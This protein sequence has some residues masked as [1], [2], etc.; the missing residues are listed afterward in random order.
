MGLYFCTMPGKIFGL[1]KNEKLKSRKA[2]EELFARG[3]SQNIF[4][5]RVSY[6]FLPAEAD[7]QAGLL[8]IG[9]S[10]SKRYFKKAVDRN[11]LKRLM[12]EAYRLQKHELLETLKQKHQKGFLFFMFTDKTMAPF[13]VVKDAMSKCLQRLNKIAEASENPS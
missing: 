2:V 11:R 4:P 9:V 1:N 6:Q 8:Q 7:E 12:R 10:V 3:K 13:P 5:I